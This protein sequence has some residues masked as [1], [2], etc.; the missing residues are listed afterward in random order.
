MAEF[1]GSGDLVQSP[2]AVRLMQRLQLCFYG[3]EE[4]FGNIRDLFTGPR[5]GDPDQPSELIGFNGTDI[6]ASR[7]EGPS[8]CYINATIPVDE[9]DACR[10]ALASLELPGAGMLV[11]D[12]FQEG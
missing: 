12:P 10:A 2:A 3:D 11:S 6:E 9:L 4:L 7:L 1:D 8:L 5:P